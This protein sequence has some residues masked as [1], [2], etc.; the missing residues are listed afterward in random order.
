MHI[1]KHFEFSHFFQIFNFSALHFVETIIERNNTDITI[2]CIFPPNNGAFFI[3]YILQ[4]TFLGLPFELLRLPEF[5]LYYFYLYTSKSQAEY[6]KVQKATYW[7]FYFGWHYAK[8]L[9]VFA[10]VMLYSTSCPLIVPCGMFD[11]LYSY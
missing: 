2:G 10:V 5:L 8:F 9:S 4:S 6:E 1:A 11:Q 3:K 7:D